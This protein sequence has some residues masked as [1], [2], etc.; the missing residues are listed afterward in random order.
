MRL[1]TVV[2]VLL[3][4]TVGALVVYLYNAPANVVTV[5]ERPV[6]EV[7]S[8]SWLPWAV[9]AGGWGWPGSYYW[10]R[11]MPRYYGP[12]WGGGSHWGGGGAPR[13]GGGGGGGGGGAPRGGGGGGGGAPRGGGGGGGGGGAP[14]GGGGGGMRK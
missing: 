8:V 14:R 7:D 11:P 12:R 10:N 13:G 1:S 4:L 6:Y 5:V 9:G 2:I 3:L